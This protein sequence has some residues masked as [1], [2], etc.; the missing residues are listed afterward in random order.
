MNTSK[1]LTKPQLSIKVQVLAAIT[2]VI[3]AVSL[4]QLFH[5][6]GAVSRLNTSLGEIFLPMHL[7]VILVGLL[8]GPYAGA[9]AGLLSPVVS[10][11][12][13]GMPSPVILPF[14]TVELCAYGLFA[15]LLRNVKLNNVLKVA[16]I[17]LSGRIVRAAA[18]LISVYAFGNTRV[19][20]STILTT[21]T[22][23]LFGIVL[24]LTLIPLIVYRAE[25]L[26]KY[27]K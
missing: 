9:A 13:S 4:P 19:G 12:L 10:L 2:A 14:M 7:P 6:I 21:V 23:G 1:A 25:H 17:Q 24:Q 11:T 22:S 27:E 8:A 5:F 26:K 16:V 18:V 20:I 15:G 3:S